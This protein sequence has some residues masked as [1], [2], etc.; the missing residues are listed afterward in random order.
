MQ[1]EI[2]QKEDRGHITK[3]RYCKVTLRWYCHFKSKQNQRIPK[4]TATPSIDGTR[5]RG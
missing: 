3:V 5:K 2:T 1:D 4:Q